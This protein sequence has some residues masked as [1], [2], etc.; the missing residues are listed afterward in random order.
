M[1]GVRQPTAERLDHEIPRESARDSTKGAWHSRLDPVSNHGEGLMGLY[2]AGIAQAHHDRWQA[3]H[4]ALIGQFGLEYRESFGT[5]TPV[6][7][8]LEERRM[9]GALATAAVRA[10]PINIVAIVERPVIKPMNASGQ[11]KLDLSVTDSN[12][13][14]FNYAV[15]AKKVA[16][17]VGV[18]VN[19]MAAAIHASAVGELASARQNGIAAYYA[20]ACFGVVQSTGP[21]GQTPA[22]SL[23]AHF[24]ADLWSELQLL[25]GDSAAVLSLVDHEA[26][27]WS[28]MPAANGAQGHFAHATF[29]YLAI[30]PS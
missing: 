7:N 3:I 6:L 13:E 10:D 11:G 27:G 23:P 12:L 20:G 9:V 8:Y 1:R 17:D 14:D 19:S 2:S 15:E 18:A 30:E 28:P 16:L 29:I 25:L 5:E 4:Q 26:F 22:A 24:E 21:R